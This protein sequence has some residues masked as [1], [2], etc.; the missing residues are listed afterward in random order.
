MH[1]G[2]D[3]YPEYWPQENWEIDARLMQEAHFDIVRVGEFAW[4]V[5][6]P[7]E[8]V[9]DFDLFDR[10]IETLGRYG[11]KVMLCTPTAA[12][13]AWVQQA[14]PEVNVLRPDGQRRSW[15]ARKNWCYNNPTMQRLSVNVTKA[16]AEHYAGH[17][18]IIAW[19]TDNE[20]S[21]SGCVCEHC[22]QAFRGW[23]GDYYASP[24]VLNR[25]WGMRFWSM[26][27]HA[28]DEIIPPL[29]RGYNPSHML[30]YRR[31]QSDAVLAFNKAQVDTIKAADPKARVTH[32][33][34]TTYSGIDYRKMARDLDFVAN[35]MYPRNIKLLGGCAYGHDVIRSYNGG[36]GFW[37]NELQC[38]YINRE[39]QLRTPPPGM[40][41]LWT[42]QAIGHGADAIIYFRWKSCTGGCE[43]FHSGVVQHDGSAK[44]RS[45]REIK[46]IGQ[47]IERLRALGL[48]GSPIKNEVAILRSFDM[49]RAMELYH[50][51]RLLDYDAELER[52]HRALLNH[53]IGVDIAHPED[54]LSAYKV[55]FCPLLML[56]TPKQVAMLQGYVETGGTLVTSFRLGAYDRHAVVPTE[57]LPGDTLSGLFGLKIHEYDCLMTDTDV[58]PVPVVRWNGQSYD[59]AV[60]A[61]MLEPAEAEV[62]ATYTNEWYA[63]YA[64][65]TRNAFGKGQAI[66]VGTALP[67]AFYDRFI[68]QVLEQAGVSAAIETPP[69]VQVTTRIVDGQPLHFVLNCTTESKAITLTRPMHDVLLDRPLGMSF[70]MPP[71]DVVVLR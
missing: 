49:C 64:A 16:M 17:P 14:Y 2:A 7:Q 6:E 63:P 27:I 51:Q 65:I 46:G 5:F 61:D 25:A 40:I 71:R 66:Y 42:H 68:S 21:Y 50:D 20:F 55:V 67:D 35:D 10:A 43:Q 39:N 57:T 19:Q 31:F 45:Y 70:V 15:G 30:D 59:A 56:T 62:L 3:Y 44:S 41:R 11:I 24:E 38:G 23:L 54:D 8:G 47:E 29:E 26:D 69:G 28:F 58:D 33:Y 60:W 1:F 9:Y 12:M 18:N 37:M 34:M 53:N 4:R 52:Y 32:N 22:V 13:P 48:A 36:A